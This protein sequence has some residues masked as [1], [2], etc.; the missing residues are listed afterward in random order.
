MAFDTMAPLNL[1]DKV[2][3]PDCE[4]DCMNGKMSHVNA[5]EDQYI[6]RQTTGNTDVDIKLSGSLQYTSTLL[7][8]VALILDR[9]IQMLSLYMKNCKRPDWTVSHG[10]FIASNV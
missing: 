8:F 1:P 5:W 7:E 6:M 2:N 3:S 10:V 9:K 4:K